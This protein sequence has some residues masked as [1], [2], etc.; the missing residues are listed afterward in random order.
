MGILGL[1]N[2]W[3]LAG[4]PERRI[5]SW[6]L[7]L[8]AALFVPAESPA[9]SSSAVRFLDAT[10]GG[11]WGIPAVSLL[12]SGGIIVSKSGRPETHERCS[13]E[14]VQNCSRA[15]SRC[16][17]KFWLL[18]VGF[19]QGSYQLLM[20]EYQIRNNEISGGRCLSVDIAHWHGWVTR[21]VGAWLKV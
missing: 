13:Q 7:A 15:A 2:P 1:I 19:E 4:V 10:S 11:C 17:H 9:A 21:D 14:A 20:F 5:V 18:E 8:M 3:K 16:C 12:G 6:P